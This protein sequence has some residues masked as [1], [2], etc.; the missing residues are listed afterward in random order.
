LT[1]GNAMLSEGVEMGNS[2]VQ[3]GREEVFGFAHIP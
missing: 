2:V 1:V 3:G